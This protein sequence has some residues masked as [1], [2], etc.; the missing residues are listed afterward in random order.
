MS[1][2]F[3]FEFEEKWVNCKSIER[4]TKY[5]LI[6]ALGNG[7]RRFNAYFRFLYNCKLPENSQFGKNNAATALNP[8]TIH[9]QQHKTS[10]CAFVFRHNWNAFSFFHCTHQI[11]GKTDWSWCLMLVCYYIFYEFLHCF[12]CWQNWT[13]R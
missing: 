6:T 10:Q 2:N 9:H 3:P 4:K 8:Y 7:D 5:P 12:R 11:E 1:H 13:K